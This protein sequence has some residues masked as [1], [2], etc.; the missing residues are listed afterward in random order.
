M[1]VGRTSLTPE[2]WKRCHQGNLC[3]YC[4]QARPGTSLKGRAHHLRGDVLLSR[5]QDSA[6]CPRPLFHVRLLLARGSRTLSTFIDSGADV[7]L[8]DEELAIQLG[9]DQVLLPHPVPASTN[10]GRSSP[11][12][13][14]SSDHTHPHAP[15]RQPSRDHTFPRP[16]I[17]SPPADPW[18]PLARSP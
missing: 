8:I 13:C 14:H 5:A 4:S 9:V 1:Q 12:D 15:V 6:P 11:V 10:R 18:L 2:E 17:T 16:V 7:S 3:L